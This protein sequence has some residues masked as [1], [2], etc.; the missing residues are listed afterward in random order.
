MLP[1]PQRPARCC[2]RDPTELSP[3]RAKAAVDWP[4]NA[5][6]VYTFHCCTSL[7]VVKEYSARGAGLTSTGGQYRRTAWPGR[8]RGGGG[9]GTQHIR[10]GHMYMVGRYHGPR[11]DVQS[12]HEHIRGAQAPSRSA[13]SAGAA[14]SRAPAPPPTQLARP[15]RLATTHSLAW[16]H[17]LDTIQ[18]SLRPS[19]TCQELADAA[20]EAPQ[21]RR[22]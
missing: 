11:R 22:H 17:E 8:A 12:S 18:R 2:R 19:L 1:L 7:G 3:E 16:T 4:P 14:P 15:A 6:S 5:A 10:G 9:E 20:P 21:E 13:P